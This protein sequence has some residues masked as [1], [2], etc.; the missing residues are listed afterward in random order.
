M[1]GDAS[2]NDMPMARPLQPFRGGPSDNGANSDAFVARIDASG[3][4]SFST[5]FGGSNDDSADC[6]VA[7]GAATVWV[8]G[9]TFSSDFPLK[10]PAWRHMR[11]P[12]PRHILDAKLRGFVAQ[13]TAGALSSSSY[14]LG[15]GLFR[16][17]AEDGVGGV[18]ILTDNKLEQEPDDRS[19]VVLEHFGDSGS[20]THSTV[21]VGGSRGDDPYQCVHDG[22]GG[23]WVVGVTQSS[24][25]CR[26]RPKV[27]PQ[28]REVAFCVRINAK[29]VLTYSRL[30]G[31]VSSTLF[32]D[33][34][35]DGNGGIWFCYDGYVD[36]SPTHRSQQGRSGGRD[37][38]LICIAGDGTLAQA[39]YLGGS[40]DDGA[41]S[42]APDG[43]GGVW[44]V[45]YTESGDFPAVAAFQASKGGGVDLF[46][47]H[48]GEPD[49]AMAEKE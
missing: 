9:E 36:D 7:S 49:T 38:A 35:P 6:I 40:R 3:Q 14:S 23:V 20:L 18:W 48:F 44:I 17:C 15:G 2:S 13:F 28:D 26:D 27:E 22:A 8:S 37:V 29:G 21:A 25:F 12:E 34:V 43:T 30:L 32:D 19:D 16:S 41:T 5:Y 33:V 47:A 42:L 24:D 1:V 31:P 11:D 45:G 46:L 39:R 10:E 4:L